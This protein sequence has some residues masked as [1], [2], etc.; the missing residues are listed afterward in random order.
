MQMD[1]RMM[2]GKPQGGGMARSLSPQPQMGPPQGGGYIKSQ[3]MPKSG[4][5]MGGGLMD[6]SQPDPSMYG[7]YNN[8]QMPPQ[9]QAMEK[10]MGNMQ[11]NAGIENA[12]NQQMQMDNRFNDSMQQVNNYQEPPASNL[13]S[14]SNFGPKP[15]QMDPRMQGQMQDMMG[16]M[17]RPPQTR[18]PAPM[19][20]YNMPGPSQ[21]YDFADR[22][23]A[24]PTS[25]MFNQMQGSQMQPALRPTGQPQ[26]M[27]QG[28][29]QPN[30]MPN[31]LNRN[32]FGR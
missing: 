4:P 8:Q 9:G 14:P 18:P 5:P 20:Q 24:S 16:R 28:M 32:R 3:V 29:Q 27:P 30:L 31:F 13:R 19:P 22:R 23:P 2:K 21:Q 26:Q 1:P 10:A 17:Q 6:K 11:M 15:G 12:N 25:N 7:R